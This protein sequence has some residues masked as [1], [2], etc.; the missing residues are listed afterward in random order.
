MLKDHG[1]TERGS[2]EHHSWGFNLRFT[3][4]QAAVGLA[5][6]EALDTRLL[7]MKQINRLYSRYLDTVPFRSDE[8]P[9][10]TDILVDDPD[11]VAARIAEAGFTARRYWKPLHRQPAYA[12]EGAFHGADHFYEHGLWLPSCFS[13]SDEDVARIIS[14]VKVP[15]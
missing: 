14:A 2:D 9:L 7:R 10:W 5:Q 11:A 8:T 12:S 6:M 3:D 13:L 1:R 15:A 4:L